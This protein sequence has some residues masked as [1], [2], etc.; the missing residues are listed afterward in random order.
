MT[1]APA[2]QAGD[3]A[4]HLEHLAGATAAS[5][6]APSRG[7][8]GRMDK[9]A[10][11]RA[12]SILALARSIRNGATPDPA[13]VKAVFAPAL[14]VN[15]AGD[16]PDAKTLAAFDAAAASLIPHLTHED[17]ADI[18]DYHGSTKGNPLLQALG[19]GAAPAAAPAAPPPPTPKPPRARKPAAPKPAAAPA[20]AGGSHEAAA[21]GLNATMGGTLEAS[22]FKKLLPAHL[23]PAQYGAGLKKLHL[24]GK[25]RI[26]K[27]ED[28]ERLRERGTGVEVDGQLFGTVSRRG[29][30]TLTPAD[31]EDAFG[32][33]PPAAP[34]KAPRAKKPAAP[35]PPTDKS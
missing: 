33:P 29:G 2:P 20:P 17:K 16:F 5:L 6:A 23:T 10:A 28:D 7:G 32:P 21:D 3:L 19:G 24:A 13:T 34:P 22:E 15:R 4:G 27:D 12:D 18:L 25:L 11:D 30:V 35:S 1:G 26:N 14:D 9:A 31:L 8:N